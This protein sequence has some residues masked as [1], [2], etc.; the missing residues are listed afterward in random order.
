MVFYHECLGGELNFQTIGESPLS[1]RMPVKM[2]DCILHA[3]LTNGSLLLMGSDMVPEKGLIVGNNL[4]ISL[5]C[6]SQKEIKNCYTK[7][8]QGGQATHPLEITFWGA[9]L[10]DLTDKFGNHWMLYFDKK[11]NQKK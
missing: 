2:K 6:N 7:L 8:S 10:G 11:T 3:T 4:T 9:W 1:S 5:H